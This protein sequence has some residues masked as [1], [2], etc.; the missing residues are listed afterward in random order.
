M[1]IGFDLSD[2]SENI[3]V[4]YTKW[5]LKW[6]AIVCVV[7]VVGFGVSEGW[8]QYQFQD[9]P[10]VAIK[11]D[12]EK[13]MDELPK[14][15][16]TKYYLVQRIRKNP[17]PSALYDPSYHQKSITLTTEPDDYRL[18]NLFQTIRPFLGTKK[19]DRTA[20]AFADFTASK[21]TG[22]FIFRDNLQ[23]YTWR[24][25]VDSEGYHMKEVGKCRQITF[26]EFYAESE[27]GLNEVKSK[28]KF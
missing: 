4:G 15:F 8:R 17:L 23:V 1:T 14:S 22:H 12:P 10:M 18:L 24:K 11:C 2:K 7:I 5:I 25:R 20:Y 19:E 13:T 6:F 21:S 28:L 26:D 16:D 27:R 3:L 9:V